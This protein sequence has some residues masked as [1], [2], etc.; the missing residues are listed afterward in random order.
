MNNPA[1]QQRRRSFRFS[2]RR[3]LHSAAYFLAVFLVLAVFFVALVLAE[4]TF[5][6]VTGR[7]VSTWALILAALI[8]AL[9][10]SPLVHA[11]QRGLD[12]VF[13]RRH[14]DV[15]QAIRHLG[16][17]DLANLPIED[18]EHALLARICKACHRESAAL[19][20]RDI[21][22]H[23]SGHKTG[24]GISAWPSGVKVPPRPETP[25]PLRLDDGSSFELCLELPRHAG[26]AWLYLGS[27]EDGKPTDEDEIEALKGLGQFAAMSL[28]HAR[29]TRRQTESARLDSLSRVAGQLHSHDLKNRLNDLSFLAH[30]INAGKLE[31]E[32]AG[33]LVTAIRKVTGRMQMLMQ[34]LADPQTP[35]NPE[36]SPL[37]VGG[38]L[39]DAIEA[40]LWPEGMDVISD[41]P[42]LPPVGGDAGMLGSVFENLFDNAVQAMQRQGKLTITAVV[43]LDSVEIRVVDTGRGMT[44]DFIRKRLFRLFSTSKENG[45]GIGLYLSKRVVEAHSGRIWAETAGE[46]KGCT[47]H[48]RLPLWQAGSR[49]KE[50]P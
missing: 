31:K 28:E 40:R 19:D 30:N 45:L 22:G 38:L 39:T 12:R 44:P 23:G 7:S 6:A 14:L 29:L 33:R 16:A 26:Q 4:S 46:G 42:S 36:L 10:F 11:M 17:G 8:A 9:L 47:F 5:Y 20:E 34:R 1:H 2:W 49:P 35:L 32:D 41:F 27:H 21:V 37:D 43:G 48:V 13:F 50:V 15:L 25:P 18:V 24:S 3:L